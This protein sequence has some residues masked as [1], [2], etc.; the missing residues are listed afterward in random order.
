MRLGRNE[1]DSRRVVGARV[2]SVYRV[3][4]HA[5]P[6][7]TVQQHELGEE[8]YGEHQL[9]AV[10]IE[11]RR[12]RHDAGV[13]DRRIESDVSVAEPIAKRVDRIEVA[14]VDLNHFD[15]GVAARGLDVFARLRD[16]ASA[17]HDDVSAALRETNRDALSKA[18]IRARYETGPT[19]ERHGRPNRF[20]LGFP[21]PLIE[22]AA[23]DG[24]N[25][26]A[27][28]SFDHSRRNVENSARLSTATRHLDVLANDGVQT[29]EHRACHQRVTDRDLL[30]VRHRK[31]GRQVHKIEVVPRVHP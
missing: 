25:G 4:N 22:K 27:V 20:N 12:H 16:A 7:Q 17:R 9:E 18:A 8:I 30:D 24:G 1:D 13:E 26:I 15:V 10:L 3:W 6:Q 29:Y 31:K 5:I 2:V 11:T 23:Q 19:R 21:A 28:S 14:E